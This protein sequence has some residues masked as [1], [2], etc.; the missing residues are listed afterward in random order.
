MKT[1]K[2][3]SEKKQ[4]N[5]QAN[6]IAAAAAIVLQVENPNRQMGSWARSYSDAK[7]KAATKSVYV[8]TQDE[9]VPDFLFK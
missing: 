1:F 7:G 9:I 5:I 8:F 4:L 3:I 2:V 6:S